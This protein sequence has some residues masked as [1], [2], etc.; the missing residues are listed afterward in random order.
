MNLYSLLSK[1]HKVLEKTSYQREYMRTIKCKFTPSTLRAGGGHLWEYCL[2][3]VLFCS[4]LYF[5]I[6]VK[7]HYCLS[8][9]FN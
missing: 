2:P 5:E 7:N 8:I 3:F 4:G 1:E 9:T 6:F